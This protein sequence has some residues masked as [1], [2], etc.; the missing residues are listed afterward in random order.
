MVPLVDLS[1]GRYGLSVL[2]QRKILQTSIDNPALHFHSQN[3]RASRKA[4][5]Q[6]RPNLNKRHTIGSVKPVSHQL[7]TR[8][9]SP[10]HARLYI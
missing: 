4:R 7:R 10:R 1:L 3:S 6:R 2:A 8:S 5:R 9:Y